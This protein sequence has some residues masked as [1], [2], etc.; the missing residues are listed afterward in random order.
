MML[1]IPTKMHLFHQRKALITVRSVGMGGFCYG[2]GA[3]FKE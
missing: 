2:W 1:Q 3:A